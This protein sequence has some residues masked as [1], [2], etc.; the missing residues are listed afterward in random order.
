MNYTKKY[1]YAFEDRYQ[2][3][4]SQGLEYW[5]VGLISVADSIERLRRFITFYG[6][7]PNNTKI[8]EFG[9]GEGHIAKY[10]IQQGYEYLGIDISPSAVTNARNLLEKANLPGDFLQGDITG[11]NMLKGDCYNV[12]IDNFCLQ[13]LVVD[14]DRYCYLAEIKRILK[15]N[16][17][18]YFH[19]ICKKDIVIDRLDSFQDYTDLYMHDFGALRDFEVFHSNKKQVIQLPK[20]PERYRSNKEYKKELNNAGFIADEIQEEENRCVIYAHK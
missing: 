8:I 14:A 18:I 10:L 12:A 6:L 11:L 17:K 7:S 5:T 3:I 2:R 20:L 13:M 19:E 1:Y 16:G 15:N 4:S 9:C